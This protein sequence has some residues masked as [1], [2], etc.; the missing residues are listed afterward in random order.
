MI[1]VFETGRDERCLVDR[2]LPSGYHDVWLPSRH[3]QRVYGGRRTH[4]RLADMRGRRKN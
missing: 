3:H 2:C 4:Q 1:C